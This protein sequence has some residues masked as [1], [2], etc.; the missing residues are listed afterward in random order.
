VRQ[1]LQIR[2]RLRVGE[3]DLAQGRTIEVP[4]GRE[5][6]GAEPLDQPLERGLPGLDDLARHLVAIEDRH[7]EGPKNFA[8]VDLPLAMPR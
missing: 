4:V 8:A 5:N 2:A 6:R 1:S 3:H 7:T